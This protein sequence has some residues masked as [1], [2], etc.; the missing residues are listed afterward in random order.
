M[1][2]KSRMLTRR[3]S[4]GLAIALIASSA[5]YFAFG[6][7]RALQSAHSIA[8]FIPANAQAYLV[9][10]RADHLIQSLSRQSRIN[11][12]KINADALA[13]AIEQS[14]NV[15]RQVIDGL[16][17][18]YRTSLDDKSLLLPSTC[19][20][21]AAG[22]SELG[23]G[24]ATG[25]TIF[26]DRMGERLGSPRASLAIGPIERDQFG[27]FL[28]S[29]TFA[30]RYALKFT[31]NDN[32]DARISK[33]SATGFRFCALQD[34]RPTILKDGSE[35]PISRSDRAV[36]AAVD[37]VPSD[38]RPTFDVECQSADK[39]RACT[40]DLL[41]YEDSAWISKGPC[42]S[43]GLAVD[44][45]LRLFRT[46]QTFIAEGTSLAEAARKHDPTM[47]ADASA[48]VP[49]RLPLIGQTT[50]PSD[51]AARWDAG[52]RTLVLMPAASRTLLQ[53][54][55]PS[56]SILRSDEFIRLS[57]A[58]SEHRSPF[59]GAIRP[60]LTSRAGFNRIVSLPFQFAGRITDTDLEARLFVNFEPLDARVLQDISKNDTFTRDEAG[61]LPISNAANLSVQDEKIGQL[62]RF[63][64]QYMLDRLVEQKT[65]I[66]LDTVASLR[67]LFARY[68][69]ERI[70]FHGE[71]GRRG[72]SG[73]MAQNQQVMLFED[74]D[75]TWGPR[76]AVAIKFQS[77]QSPI[78][79]V[80]RELQ[81]VVSGMERRILFNATRQAKRDV[82]LPDDDI[83]AIDESDD[84]DDSDTTTN[85]GDDDDDDH[86]YR[87]PLKERLKDLLGA[88]RWSALKRKYDFD[89]LTLELHVRK[90]GAAD[91][92]CDAAKRSIMVNDTKRDV[93][94]L[95]LPVDD[96]ARRFYYRIPELI[97]ISEQRKR[98]AQT[99]IVS[100]SD[101][102][103]KLR[104][105]IDARGRAVRMMARYRPNRANPAPLTSAINTEIQ[106]LNVV[107]QG[108]GFDRIPATAKT[109]EE[110][111]AFIETNG[112]EE[113]E[114]VADRKSALDALQA[115][116][117]A[118]VRNRDRDSQSFSTFIERLKNE[119][120]PIIA[121]IDHSRRTLFVANSIDALGQAMIVAGKP[122]GATAPGGVGERVRLS[123]PSDT[124]MRWIL[125][126]RP[127]GSSNWLQA[128][129]SGRVL[130]WGRSEVGVTSEQNSVTFRLSLHDR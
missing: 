69:L 16:Q 28:A 27:R 103:T 5:A 112:L 107:L 84:D 97:Q 88:E 130:P 118:L 85:D 76:S 106:Q 86:P 74:T 32:V 95:T 45:E 75:V 126:T 78:D 109:I 56:T 8:Q 98:D 128:Q 68:L 83:D 121:T 99:T 77:H 73:Y 65:S 34:G 59:F 79:F 110:V 49:V 47:Q 30:G 21:M 9:L 39:S 81:R 29:A 123:A 60:D 96:V 82:P 92:A 19:A 38:A 71:P 114:A 62:V 37:F 102:R 120:L 18:I 43:A 101:A 127:R 66:D 124:A 41:A 115:E 100:K 117:N 44:D 52:S 111:L 57:K 105:E 58:A 20:D 40:C 13:A 70:G 33:L 17:S 129:K 4:L 61:I 46:V 90:I 24:A 2:R 80:C 93:Y 48:S 23:I 87:T 3:A 14:P 50:L 12:S 26:I 54:P 108:A 6:E 11:I 67:G 63:A 25:A 15:V 104:A 122:E 31:T 55:T 116:L 35:L 113:E 7:I 42:K 1:M 91:Q 94:Y 53:Q 64:D 51:L 10:P 119:G 125:E 89:P 36:L 22:G 72:P